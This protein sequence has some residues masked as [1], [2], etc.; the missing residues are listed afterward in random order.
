MALLAGGV[1]ACGSVVFPGEWRR[2][3]ALDLAAAAIGV[4]AGLIL[5]SMLAFRGDD[6]VGP[7]CIGLGCAGVARFAVTGRASR[8]LA[9]WP[10]RVLVVCLAGW[11]LLFDVGPLGY[12]LLPAMQSMRAQ[13]L[14]AG[15]PVALAGA[16]LAAGALWLG[17][18]F[19]GGSAGRGNVVVNLGVV[20]AAVV[21]VFVAAVVVVAVWPS[22][23]RTGLRLARQSPMAVVWSP[24]GTT[25][26]VRGNDKVSLYDATTLRLKA[27]PWSSGPGIGVAW[28]PDGKTLAAATG[29]SVD[30]WDVERATKT[31][32]LL[33]DGNSWLV[34]W[35]PDGR[36]LCVSS[37]VGKVEFWSVAGRRRLAEFKTLTADA[38][39][40]AWRPKADL[41]VAGDDVSAISS[42]ASTSWESG[43]VVRSPFAAES[44]TKFSGGVDSMAWSPDGKLLAVGSESDLYVLDGDTGSKRASFSG[45]H[46]GYPLSWSA[47]GTTIATADFFGIELYDVASGA[48]Q[49][50]P[51]PWGVH[52]DGF[53]WG[54]E[55]KVAAVY[56]SSFALEQTWSSVVWIWDLTDA[57][58]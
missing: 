10:V 2:A 43:T 53:A 3:L 45:P 27:G 14:L 57:V 54:P 47:D 6:W 58:K 16:L 20:G 11:A 25:L 17:S 5:A 48:F 31:A 7:V 24:D 38:T 46:E 52:P 12:I 36:K 39:A 56:S 8:V 22:G 13:F 9:S 28:S 19:A 42:F 50:V 29:Q 15:V 21:A 30:L 26:A 33:V 4:V 34:A 23:L 49:E 35:S 32:E 37:S 41:L 44:M 40:I 51:L 1:A 55:G 18:A